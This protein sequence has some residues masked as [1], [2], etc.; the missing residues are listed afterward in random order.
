LRAPPESPSAPLRLTDVLGALPKAELD[1]LIRRLG[2]RIDPAKRLD[3]P[4]QVA[5]ALVQLPD[6]RDPSRLPPS[7]IELLHR[8]AEANGVL[9]VTAIPAALEPLA[10][11]GMVFARGK[12]GAIELI[13]PTAYLIQLRSWEGEDPRGLRAL[14]AQAP[15][16]TASAVAAHYLG[17]PAT[18]PVSLS[19]EAAWECLS[20][21]ERLAEELGRLAPTERAALEAI[22]QQGGEVETDELLEIEREPLRMRTAQGPTQ[23][24]RGVGFSL[25][26]RGFLL[27]VHPNRHI[28][29]TEIARVIGASK[30]ADRERRRRDL[31]SFVLGGDH[32]PRRARFSED[33]GALALG[34]ALVVREPGAEIKP[35]LGT[36]K[37]LVQKLALR[38]GRD[39]GQ[40]AMLIAL[41]R[42]IGLWDASALS[43]S[44]PPGAH[45]LGDLAPVLFQ[46]WLRG[47]AWD[48]A[49][50]DPEQLRIGPEARDGSP[51]GVVR[52]IVLEALRDL[53]TDWLPLDAVT[54]YFDNDHRVPGLTRLFR[55]WCDR[56]ELEPTTPRAAAHRVLTES[57]PALGVLDLGDE[58]EGRLSLRMTPRGRALLSGEALHAD[59]ARSKFL[60]THVLRL[61][62]RAR[63]AAV[64]AAANFV[65][66]GRVG[67]TLDLL[68]APQILAR[69]LAA[70]VEA[71][72]LR[73]R[74]EALAPLPE[75]LSRTLEA[76]SLVLGRATFAGASG[77]LWL[78]DPE[79]REL[80]LR[81]KATQ[82]LFVDP[83]PRGG[84]LVQPGIDL[85]RVARRCRSVG[86]E[87]LSEG[88]VVRGRTGAPPAV[89]PRT[90]SSAR[91]QKPD[92]T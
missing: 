34:L 20:D 32:A 60:D 47:G 84:L 85:E 78:D 65:E 62:P 52:Q 23:T 45:R 56:V 86:V 28:V 18:P 42:A 22:E 26:R 58:D 31:R 14:L 46:A 8:V 82:D 19:L 33:P 91:L 49:R 51:V 71:D 76:A 79:V 10:A 25:E 41:S 27:P 53:G 9:F 13:L 87:V 83:S 36:P 63:V 69:A 72:V 29:P 88:V 15:F 67:A 44:G 50:P 73:Q 59:E 90:R 16:E 81:A 92:K 74:I 2:V 17:R 12:K 48:E 35:A 4:A 80:L 11:R 55:R 1:N 43:A 66:V 75:S 68:V 77:F 38:F 37:S 6:L 21:P 39:V 61:G 64:L 40:V 54:S 70:G 7:S 89:A 5:R 30:H 3:V 57:L 24:R